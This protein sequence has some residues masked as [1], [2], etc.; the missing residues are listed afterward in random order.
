MLNTD[1]VSWVAPLVASGTEADDEAEPSDLPAPVPDPE[2]EP[3]D[4]LPVEVG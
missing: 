4:L 1:P 2:P 3:S